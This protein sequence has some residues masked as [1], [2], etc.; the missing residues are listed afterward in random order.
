MHIIITSIGDV[1]SDLLCE[2][3][4]GDVLRLNWECWS[5]YRLEIDGDRFCLADRFG[6]RVTNS[7]LGNIIWRKPVPEVDLEPGESWYS[8]REFKYAVMSIVD[9]V[10]RTCPARLPID[11]RHNAGVDKFWQLQAASRHLPTPRWRFTSV[12]SRAD[13]SGFS[14][15]V[16]S[17]TGEPIPGTGDPA[18]V[19]Y[20]SDADPGSLADGFPWF[21]Q[22]RVSAPCDLTVVYVDGRQFGF[23]LERSQ[24]SGLDW[25][26]HIGDPA[27]DLAWE[28]ATLSPGLQAALGSVMR[29][30]GLRFGRV[31]LLA[32]ESGDVGEATFLEV[33][34]NGQWAWLDPR[35]DNGLFD[36]VVAFL[37]GTVAVHAA[38]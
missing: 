16:K 27:I 37:T 13:W 14:W 30:L 21:V 20:T 24:F 38:V 32:R 31:D 11:P 6:R 18:K 2:R 10:R 19:I 23:T 17:A 33:N 12:P 5:E 34:P 4:E 8:F 22:E 28:A 9:Q 26:R 1:T 29:D 3:L 25:R 36:A 15:V 35:Q 7:S